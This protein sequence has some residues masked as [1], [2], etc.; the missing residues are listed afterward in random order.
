MSCI[1]YRTNP[2]TGVK[3]AYRSESYRDPTTKKPKNRREY[4]GRVDPETQ[5]IIPKAEDGKRNRSKLGVPNTNDDVMPK[6]VSDVIAEQRNEIEHL[7]NVIDELREQQ[8]QTKKALT[9]IRDAIDE[10]LNL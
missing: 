2:K 5:K 10:Q 7:H 8:L 9:K 6:E 3:Y 1:V 4:L